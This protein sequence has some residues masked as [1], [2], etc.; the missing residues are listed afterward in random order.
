VKLRPLRDEDH[1]ALLELW[2][3]AGLPARPRGRDRRERIAR[4]IEGPCSAF[5][6]VEDRGALV[7][8]VLGTHDGR[9]GWINRLAVDPDHRGRGLGRRL[10]ETVEEALRGAGIEIVTCLV[11]DWNAE[12]Q[13]FFA[14]LGYQAHPDIRYFSKR[15]DPDI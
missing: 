4:E 8:A 9:K 7:A 11:E 10:V 13:A 1:A 3:R 14:H 6:V 5:F 12:S 2:K 15:R